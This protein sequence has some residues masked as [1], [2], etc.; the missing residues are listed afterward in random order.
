MIPFWI[1]DHLPELVQMLVVG[2]GVVVTL[3]QMMLGAGCHR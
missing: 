1:S 2:T 3:V